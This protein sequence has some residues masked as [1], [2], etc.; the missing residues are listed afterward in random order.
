MGLPGS[1]DASSL[2]GRVE[3]LEAD[4]T[5]RQESYI[6]R[7]RAYNLRVEELEDEV[8]RLKAG[9]TGWMREDKNMQNLKTMHTSILHNVELVQDRTAKIMQVGL[10]TLHNTV[11][12]RETVITIALSPLYLSRH[13]R[14]IPNY[15]SHNSF[16]SHA[17]AREGPVESVSS[18]PVRCADR[19]REGEA[20]EE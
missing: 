14:Y 19:A 17:G 2:K 11:L 6:R 10:Y 13:W 3:A 18:S 20:E 9:K 5:R 7:E 4:L 16:L 8:S 15:C 12:Y 1:E